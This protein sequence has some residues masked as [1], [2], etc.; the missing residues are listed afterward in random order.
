MGH[1]LN[2]DHNN[3]LTKAVDMAKKETVI[4]H[5]DGVPAAMLIS[6]NGKKIN[7]PSETL[8]DSLDEGIFALSGSWSE[9]DCKD[10]EAA[11]APFQEIDES[12][13]K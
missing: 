2:I 11:T 9:E 6:L 5:K 4:F 13:W 10:F 7:P 8:Q 1:V 3:E 12:L